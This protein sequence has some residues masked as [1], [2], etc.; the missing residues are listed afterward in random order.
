MDTKQVASEALPALDDT[1]A[2][3]ATVGVTPATARAAATRNFVWLML[4]K[5]LGIF[6]GLAVFGLIARWFGSAASGHFA[7]ALALLQTALGLSL[8]CSAAVLLPRVYR[9]RNGIAAALANV[10]IV[11]MIGSVLAAAGAAVFSLVAIGDPERLRITLLVLLAV[12]LIE[13]FYTAVVYWQSRND[14]R[15]PTL[16]RAA[17]LMTRAAVVI[18]AILLGAPLW[19][20]AFA[21]VMEAAV[22]ATLLYASVRPLASL[23]IFMRRV[24]PQRSLTYMRFGVRF[25]LGLCLSNLFLRLDRLMLGT[26]LPAPEF[27]VYASAMQLVDVW[28]QVAYLTGFAI[29]P[30]FLYKALASNDRM[31]LWRMAAMLA[32]LGSIGLVGALIFGELAMRLVFGPNFVAGAPYLVAGTAFGVL[33]FVDQVMNVRVTAGNRPLALAIKWAAA[34]LGAV[35]VQA[36][37]YHSLGAYAG[38]LGLAAGIVCGWIAM[39]AALWAA[40]AQDFKRVPA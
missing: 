16:C 33:L 28:L 6:F 26:L 30:V 5:A 20:V 24:S 14:N 36:A 22:S 19:M 29:G 23:R 10:F 3:A 35:A 9:M 12:P 7:Y 13:P 37:A 2:E 27:G 11:R 38:P 40:P 4:D 34:C 31:Q 18:L 32:G 39:W 21:W 8:V 1:E 17:G 15:H 25:L